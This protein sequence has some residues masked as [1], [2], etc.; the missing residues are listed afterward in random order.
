M[1]YQFKAGDRIR[2]KVD[3]YPAKK[4]GIYKLAYGDRDNL[5]ACREDGFSVCEGEDHWE[6]ITDKYY[7]GQEVK[8]TMGGNMKIIYIADPIG[9]SGHKYV[10]QYEDDGRICGCT[11][12]ELNKCNPQE[13]KELTLADIE[14]KFGC[15]VKIIK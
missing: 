7:V 1:T 14:E 5:C 6:L 2:M 13:T 4:G 8:N 10:L 3:C 15:K 11:E 12:E 9:V